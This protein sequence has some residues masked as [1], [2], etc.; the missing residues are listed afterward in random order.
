[1]VGLCFVK[2]FY[3]IVEIRVEKNSQDSHIVLTD[4]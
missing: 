4:A 2:K 3:Y 1:M